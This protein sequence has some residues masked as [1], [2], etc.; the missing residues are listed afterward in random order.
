MD[1][2]W[3][4]Q[5]PNRS[6]ESYK[7]GVSCLLNVHISSCQFY[8]QNKTFCLVSIETLALNQNVDLS[9]FV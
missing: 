6:Q 5:K 8:F 2:L 4:L 1:V 3:L 7:R 9:H